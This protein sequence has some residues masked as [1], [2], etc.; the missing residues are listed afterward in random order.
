MLTLIATV[1]WL[2]SLH[3]L[4]PRT[5]KA[6]SWEMVLFQLIR[7]PWALLGCIHA[8]GGRITGRDFAF[9]VTPKGRTGMLPLPAK[10]VAPYLLLAVI[11]AAPTVFDVD[12]GAANGYKTLTLINTAL[13]LLAAIAIVA[14][15][16]REHPSTTRPAM[17]RT[18]APQ[19][20]A[21]AACTTCLLGA[22]AL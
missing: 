4:R 16:V 5:A 10:V 9:K 6:L 19:T 7:W 12:A 8:I 18:I 14:L 3:W 1:V 17:L 2:R 13:Y 20:L 11:S 15:H 21:T 22:L